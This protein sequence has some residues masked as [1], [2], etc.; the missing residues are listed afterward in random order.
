MG[1]RSLHNRVTTASALAAVVASLVT[2]VVSLFVVD[3]RATS[4][5]E[6]RALSKAQ[7]FIDE[8][9]VELVTVESVRHLDI[10]DEVREFSH[11][12]DTIT[13]YLHGVRVAGSPQLDLA[14]AD[15]CKPNAESEDHWLVC[16]ASSAPHGLVALVGQSRTDVL[17]H[18]GPLLTGGLISV[19]VLLIGGVFAGFWVSRWSLR[20][21]H[22]LREVLEGVDPNAPATAALPRADT[23]EVN[24]VVA[25]LDTLLVKLGR[26][27][28]RSRRFSADAA[29]ELR[30]PLTKLRTELELLAEADAQRGPDSVYPA[31]VERTAELGQLLERL[32]VLASPEQ[33][34][35]RD[36]LVSM[37]VVAEEALET[38]GP[39]ATRV[40]LQCEGDGTVLGDGGL[41][42]IVVKNAI[43]N[44]LKF[45][46]GPI[47][48]QVTE[49]PGEV[50]VRIDDEGP[51]LDA[52]QRARAF[53]PFFRGRGARGVAGH[54]IGLALVEHVTRA[55]RGSVAFVGTQPG[56]HLSIRLPRAKMPG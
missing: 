22:R 4:M 45:S 50:E 44:A 12:G 49:R 10:E 8:L 17:A 13:V 11:A 6:Q 53:E 14:T 21:L 7:A 38:L 27:I 33:A 24:A 47:A 54:G 34:L 56:A 35:Q 30:T 18:R 25:V 26:E 9:E 20:P 3:A 5:A 28:D 16:Q 55:H 52:G 2:L 32:L 43:D 41:L 29:H 19:L 1:R 31:L 15:G 36:A 48:V 23:E 39:D 40:S 42:A 46:D 51:G 37:S